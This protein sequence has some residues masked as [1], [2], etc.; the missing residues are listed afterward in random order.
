MG[1]KGGREEGLWR[2]L[3]VGLEG[4]SELWLM[5]ASESESEYWTRAMIRN[6]PLQSRVRVSLY[7]Q[8]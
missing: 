6:L 2:G 4:S 1:G 8:L 3:L 7:S 5:S